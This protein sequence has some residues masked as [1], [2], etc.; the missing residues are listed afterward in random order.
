MNARAAAIGG[1]ITETPL[2]DWAEATR[3]RDAGIAASV[4][5]ADQVN[6]NWSARASEYLL[7]YARR[8]GGA[9]LA[10][11]VREYAHGEGLEYPPDGRA[12]GAVLSRAARA[13]L[14]RQI[15]YAP[16]KSS[17]R[18]PKVLWKSGTAP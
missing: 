16:A 13:G 12:W 6:A 5:H 11:Q 10:E 1:E 17:N 4:E 2:L 3:R 18:S 8:A 15:G 14:I 7:D 9:F